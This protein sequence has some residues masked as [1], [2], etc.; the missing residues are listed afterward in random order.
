MRALAPFVLAF[1][2]ACNG[3]ASTTAPA[4]VVPPGI[5]VLFRTYRN[6]TCYRLQR[7]EGPIE[8]VCFACRGCSSDE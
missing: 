5:R 6:C 4:E 2:G 3:C 7:S 8:A 1:L